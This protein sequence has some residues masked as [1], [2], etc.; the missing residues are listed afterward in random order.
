[1]KRRKQKQKKFHN[2]QKVLVEVIPGHLRR[3]EAAITGDAERIFDLNSGK[4][5]NYKTISATRLQRTGL[6]HLGDEL[7]IQITYQSLYLSRTFDPISYF[8]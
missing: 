4:W 2:L 7:Q 6:I 1:M 5:Q 3:I 8:H